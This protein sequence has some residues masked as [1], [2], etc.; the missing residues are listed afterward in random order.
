VHSYAPYARHDI[1]FFHRMRIPWGQLRR[2]RNRGLY[3][4][5]RLAQPVLKL[6]E[7]LAPGQSNNFAA[8][9][10]KPDLSRTLHPWLQRSGGAVEVNSDWLAG[11][12]RTATVP[13]TP[14]KPS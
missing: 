13:R 14:H 4:A 1:R 5:V 11:R 9:I 10:L 12:Y 6:V 8:V 3:I 2:R 7:V